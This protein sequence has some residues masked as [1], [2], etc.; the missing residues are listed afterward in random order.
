MIDSI[1]NFKCN[2]LLACYWLVLYWVPLIYCG[3]YYTVRTSKDYLYDKKNREFYK[4]AYHPTLTIGVII[5]RGV[6]STLPVVN[7]IAALFDVSPV[8]FRRFFLLIGNALNRPVVPR[9][10]K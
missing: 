4:T 6:G 1:L 5:G 9:S 10:P 3:I 8:V 7:L 2:S